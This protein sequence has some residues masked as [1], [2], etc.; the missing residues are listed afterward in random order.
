[1]RTEVKKTV[2][3]YWRALPRVRV[4]RIT[5]YFYC[6][7]AVKGE[8]RAVTVEISGEKKTRFINLFRAAEVGFTRWNFQ[9]KKKINENTLKISYVGTTTTTTTT[10]TV[11]LRFIFVIVT[12]P[13]S[14]R[15]LDRNVSHLFRKPHFP[16]LL[17]V[18]R[19]ND[20]SYIMLCMLLSKSYAVHVIIII[21]YI[22]KPRTR[23]SQ[24]MR[25][26]SYFRL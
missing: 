8:A 19:R 1:M 5:L 14:F 22:Y 13:R 3:Y 9:G 26:R 11:T 24:A 4:I 16:R 6:N 23:L 20:A 12:S 15:R 25:I 2:L 17:Y 10:M 7:V 21:K 18:R